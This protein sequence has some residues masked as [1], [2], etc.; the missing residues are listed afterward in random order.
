MLVVAIAC[1]S[2]AC[3][4]HPEV[5]PFDYETI[6][7]DN[8]SLSPLFS[9]GN[10]HGIITAEGCKVFPGD[11]EWPSGQT[12]SLFNKTLDGSVIQTV[13]LAAPCYASWSEYDP[14]ECEAI[15]SA[16]NDSSLQYDPSVIFLNGKME[17]RN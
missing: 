2:A 6:Q 9:S 17:D 15:T 8:N 5:K 3:L 11:A 14:G 16:W 10:S 4:A 13:L 1:L 7:L 12:W